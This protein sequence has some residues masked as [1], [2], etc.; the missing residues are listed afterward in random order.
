MAEIFGRESSGWRADWLAVAVAISLPWSTSLTIIFVV[1]WLITLIGSW[2]IS[3]LRNEILTAAGGLPVALWVLGA[4]G[5]LWA[6]APMT[7]RID[8]LNAFH[9]LLAIPFL[10]AQFRRSD[11]GVYVLIGFLASCTVLL[12]VSW[13][14]VLLPDLPW[15]GRARMG[16]AGVGIPVKDNITQSI[17]FS[18]CLLGLADRAF[19]A[20]CAT[21][22]SFAFA[23]VALALLFLANI[24][25]V[26]TSRT[27]LVVIPILFLLFVL[28]RLGWKAAASS[29]LAIIALAA[30]VWPTSP[31]L[32]ERITNLYED[33][34]NYQPSAMSSPGGERLDFWRNS[35]VFIAEAPV[36]G[37][38]T[39]SIREQFRRT[40]TG[41]LA[42]ATNPHN[43]ILAIAIQLG[44][45]G[46]ILL[47]AMWISQLRLFFR[48]GLAAGIG[49]A[50]VVQSVVSSLFNSSLFDFATGWA[51]VWG[52]G[53]LCGMTL[54]SGN[55]EPVDGKKTAV[56]DPPKSA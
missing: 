20:W 14:L 40:G 33:L 16:A 7:E 3:S 30:A 49:V 5:M 21:R 12:I 50:V 54:H 52:V 8:G 11:R 19:R 39:G 37:H 2:E 28:M 34:R 4:L 47:L 31:F 53:V 48:P 29:V 27:A 13:A 26:S 45:V 10:I 44:L 17:M 42:M 35:L 38:G 56:S 24:L 22:R 23:L 9:K 25:Y 1:L 51:Y 18:L 6:G 46:S 41:R 36:L 15:R 32:R 55:I 43:Q